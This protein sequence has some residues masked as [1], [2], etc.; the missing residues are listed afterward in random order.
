MGSERTCE[1]LAFGQLTR[2]EN[3]EQRRRGKS[4]SLRSIE[5]ER[6][7]KSAVGR[8]GVGKK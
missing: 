2:S 7:S 4:N 6:M 1:M 3:E 8:G 5:L